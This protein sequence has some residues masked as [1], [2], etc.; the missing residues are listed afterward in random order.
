MAARFMFST[1][2]GTP[3][4]MAAACSTSS[5]AANLS[6]LTPSGSGMVTVL[7]S[8]G[9]RSKKLSEKGSVVSGVYSPTN[10]A[11]LSAVSVMCAFP[12]LS[13]AFTTM[14]ASGR[15]SL[16]SLPKMR[17][18]RET[19]SPFSSVKTT[20]AAFPL[21]SRRRAI[22]AS[23]SA[24]T[25]RLSSAGASKSAVLSNASPVP[26]MFT[27][28]S[29]SVRRRAFMVSLSTHTLSVFLSVYTLAE[30]GAKNS[31]AL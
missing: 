13:S 1:M 22:S 3:G 14:S 26:S 18:R 17:V 9:M 10:R 27:T 31:F 28:V 20:S 21:S 30:S 8:P 4:R 2:R 24:S 19:S 5:S 16:F 15:S 11:N 12:S 25:S 29:L 7:L 23:G 6:A